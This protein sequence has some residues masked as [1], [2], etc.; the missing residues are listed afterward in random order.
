MELFDTPLVPSRL[1]RNSGNFAEVRQIAESGGHHPVLMVNTNRYTP[2]PGF[3]D[4]CAYLGPLTLD[5]LPYC[6]NWSWS[7][8]AGEGDCVDEGGGDPIPLLHSI[9]T[10]RLL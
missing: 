3:P 1:P 7:Q 4:H 8:K 2:D 6:R 5:G 9:P 10:L